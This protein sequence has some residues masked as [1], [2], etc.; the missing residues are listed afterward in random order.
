MLGTVV[1]AYSAVT[2]PI[3]PASVRQ[4]RTGSNFIRALRANGGSCAYVP[5]SSI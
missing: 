1:A 2:L 5:T 3:A 4:Q